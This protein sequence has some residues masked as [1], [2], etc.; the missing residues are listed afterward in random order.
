[1]KTNGYVLALC[2]LVAVFALAACQAPGPVFAGQS[3]NDRAAQGYA[4]VAAVHSMSATLLDGHV[5]G[6]KDAENVVQ[7]ADI[8]RDGIDIAKGLTGQAAETRLDV[9]L[10]ALQA[11]KSYLCQQ[12]PTNPN[13]VR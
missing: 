1:M 4:A 2:L 11:A 12:Q 9:A 3:F 8:A 13:C 5:I 6:S 7:Q 10:L